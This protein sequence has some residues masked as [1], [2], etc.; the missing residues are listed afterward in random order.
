MVDQVRFPF[1]SGRW[2]LVPHKFLTTKELSITVASMTTR[3]YHPTTFEAFDVP[4]NKAS[5]LVLNAGWTKTKPTVVST[6]PAPVA[7]VVAEPISYVTAEQV[8]E[9]FSAPEVPAVVEDENGWRGTTGRRARKSD[10]SEDS[11]EA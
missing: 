2:K 5:E 1:D 3:V 6:E 4:F 11:A 7:E 10:A 8:E 9:F